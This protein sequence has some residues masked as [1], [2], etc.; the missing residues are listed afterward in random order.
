MTRS[1][2]TRTGWVTA[3]LV[4]LAAVAWLFLAPARIGGSTSYVTTHGDSMA[5]RFESG[6]L[7]LIR[8]ADDYRVGQIVAYRSKLLNTVVLHRIIGRDGARYVFK[9]DNNDF[10]DPTRPDRTELIGRLWLHVPRGGGVLAALTSRLSAA[11]LAGC[12][13]LLLLLG[14]GRQR[15]RRDRR[16]P[17]AAPPLRQANRCMASSPS[18]PT[19]ALDGR[20]MLLIGVAVSVALLAL[21]I[22][23]FTRPPTTP[24]TVKSAY[25]EKVSFGY[26]ANAAAGPVYRGGIVRTGDPIFVRLVDR[27]R[28]KIDYRFVAAARHNLAGTYDVLLRLT[29]PTGWTRSTRLAP[30]RRFA[31]DHTSRQVTLDLPYLRSLIHRVETLTGAP[32]GGAYTLTITPRVHVAGKLD[33]QP[34]T[35]EFRP[36]LSFQLDALQLRPGSGS[37]ATD[38]DEGGLAPSRRGSVTAAATAANT[39]G[40]GAR[41]VPVPTART[42]ALVGFVLAALSTLLIALRRHG[43]PS[44]PAAHIRRRYG[45]LIVPIAGT[46]PTPPHPPIDVTSIDVLAKLAERSE[47]LI[48][49]HQRDGLDTYLV[50]DEGT[51]Y[52]YQARRAGHHDADAAT[53]SESR[54]SSSANGD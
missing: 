38:V 40:V 31:G 9:G 21:A 4:L 7:A 12:A 28:V 47:R 44:D 15:R 8:P 22:F 41:R 13:A 18:G 1:R 49:H 54:K 39:I 10:V 24:T 36:A 3:A 16:Q 17:G 14:A 27:V 20:A 37:A 34:L 42:I 23:A 32:E 43:R 2:F 53:L 52:R 33:G 50:D 30:R 45:R 26:R 29:G 46:A 25:V 19:P 11:A 48:L 35:S 5:P 51:L 6:D